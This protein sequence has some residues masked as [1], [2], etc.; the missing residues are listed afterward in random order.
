MEELLE[1][2]SQFSLRLDGD[3]EMD[4][5]VLSTII[6]NMA[7]LAK[8]VTLHEHPNTEVKTKVS[9]LN[10][11]SFEIGFVLECVAA[12]SLFIAGGG[13]PVAAQTIKTVIDVFNIKKHLKGKQPKEIKKLDNGS[14]GI[15]NEEG[16][17]INIPN[18]SG[19]AF[20]NSTVQGLV[21][22]IGTHIH[23]HSPDGN[24]S[25]KNHNGDHEFTPDDVKSIATP[26]LTTQE[27]I[28]RKV[29]TITCN[30]VI[31]KPDLL[32]RSSWEFKYKDR[33]IHA[34]IE[35][36]DFLNTVHNGTPVRAGD[37]INATFEH[38]IEIDNSEQPIDSSEKY[39][40]KTV[41]GS[42]Q[43]SPTQIDLT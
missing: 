24:F 29:T 7:E 43:S 25:I 39:F 18:N 4:A 22:N 27:T 35:D 5:Y 15:V 33:T 10:K 14:W 26:L 16:Q 32:G 19:A 13:A 12:Y 34:K 17:T 21:Q 11:G 30:L 36:E 28:T 42:I 1:N 8:A 2:Q 20:V 38:S 37:Y 40:I 6:K 3:S 41:H 9:A 23:V 31:K